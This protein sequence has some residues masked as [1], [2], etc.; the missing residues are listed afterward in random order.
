M[1]FLKQNHELYYL[2]YLLMYFS[3][4]RLEHVVKIVEGWSP[5]EEVY[6]DMMEEWSTRLVCFKEKGFCRYYVGLHGSQKPCEWVYFPRSLLPLLEKHKGAKRDRSSVSDYANYHNL[7]RP[8]YLRKLN[9]R[10]LEVVIPKEDVA[11]FIQSRLGEIEKKITKAVYSDL[12]TK[13]DLWYPDVMEVLEKG[14]EDVEYLKKV[15]SSKEFRRG[16]ED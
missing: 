16:A 4:V 15:L 1:E 13:A 2:Y 10:M 9:W 6:I 11:R 12:L 8:K 7:L 3:G 5:E 14:L